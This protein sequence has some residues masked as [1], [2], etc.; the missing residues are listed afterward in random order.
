MTC[1]VV[2]SEHNQRTS[3]S[4]SL[5][6]WELTVAGSLLAGV[7]KVG[8]LF[9]SWRCGPWKLPP[10]AGSAWTQSTKCPWCC[11]P[12]VTSSRKH[13]QQRVLLFFFFF[14]LTWQP[15]VWQAACTLEFTSPLSTPKLR[16]ESVLNCFALVDYLVW[17]PDPCNK[18]SDDNIY[19]A[20]KKPL[21]CEIYFCK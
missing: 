3:L 14:F 16:L 15:R 2:Y 19:K 12:W 17:N 18:Y 21:S 6:S 10:W 9:L 8:P 11:F 4:A 5:C 1:R 7:S 20:E 13:E